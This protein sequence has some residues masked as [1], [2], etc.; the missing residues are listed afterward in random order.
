ML[1][2]DCVLNIVIDVISALSGMYLYCCLLRTG[3]M[4]EHVLSGETAAPYSEFRAGLMSSSCCLI[5]PCLHLPAQPL[6]H[7]Q[8]TLTIPCAA[9]VVHGTAMAEICCRPLQFA[10]CRPLLLVFQ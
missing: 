4:Y 2:L 10:L 6:Q 9:M 8:H 5:L 3:Y 1:L 7:L